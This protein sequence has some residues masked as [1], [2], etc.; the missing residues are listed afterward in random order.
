MNK[1]L[2][3]K[4]SWKNRGRMIMCRM[5]VSKERNKKEFEF[6]V[7]NVVLSETKGRFTTDLI[8]DRLHQHQIEAEISKLENLFEQWTE[9]GFLFENA[10][11]YVV[12]TMAM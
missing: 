8:Y 10:K 5:L 3:T 7:Y 6:I 9:N 4:K 1:L 12:N 2:S 11:E